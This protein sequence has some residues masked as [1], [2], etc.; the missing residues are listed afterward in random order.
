MPE[1]LERKAL[2]LGW[3]K[4][5]VRRALELRIGAHQIEF[6]QEQQ[7]RSNE[8]VLEL[9]ERREQLMFGTL[10]VREA[11]G[12]DD[13]ALAEM[14][15]NSPEEIGDWEVTTERS[16]NPF[17]Q[18]W[19]QEHTNMQVLED[20]GVILAA[21]AHSTRNTII[22]GR[23]VSAH[24][25]TGFRVRQEARG[26]GYSHALRM[27]EGPA[28][29]WYGMFTYYY[30]RLDNTGALEWIKALQPEMVEGLPNTGE[31]VPGLPVSV[32]HLTPRPFEGATSAI[33]QAQPSDVP[34]C[35]E[36]INQSH[37][38]L[39]LFRPYTVE[40][41]RA[42][43][44]GPVAGLQPD[45]HSHVYG[46]EDF[47]VLEEDGRVIACAGL[48]D[49]GNDMREVWRHRETGERRTVASTALMD[50]G[51]AEGREDAMAQLVNHLAGE[52]AELGRD[53]LI[54]PLQFAPQ[55]VEEL[56]PHDPRAETRALQFQIEPDISELEGIS[57]SRPYTDLAYW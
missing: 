49:R 48:W 24:V 29:S 46:W 45:F 6:W 28:R 37:H 31:G 34:G 53:S 51:Y 17:A 25:Q 39:D 52:T 15:A 54:A 44:D 9:L 41:L 4:G 20:R 56:E 11:T 14:Y 26:L 43:L 10:R 19:L 23:R 22:G 55:L 12:D 1:E 21:S 38:G 2:E 35:V 40:F 42:R 33:S 30:V 36:L 13:E 32:Y 5:L 27:A 47:Y 7:Q 8:G 3:E 50:F 16:P 18:L 57:L